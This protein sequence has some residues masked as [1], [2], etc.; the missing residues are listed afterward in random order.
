M[1]F[2]YKTWLIDKMLFF[3]ISDIDFGNTD[4]MDTSEP[5]TIDKSQMW[6]EKDADKHDENVF[7]KVWEAEFT[8]ASKMS[9]ST[10]QT[11][12]EDKPL[13]LPMTI[14]ETTGTKV[15]RFFWWDAFEDP[16]KQPGTVYLFG[17]VFV[18]SLNEYV[19]CSLAVKNIPRRIY[20][21]PRDVVR[22]NKL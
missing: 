11:A 4:D 21:L 22:T 14:D 8:Q 17:K 2:S 15:F 9:S 16:Y 6:K 18:E 13:P 20:L 1:Q 19:S 3:Q 5:Q 10:V 7:A 12:P